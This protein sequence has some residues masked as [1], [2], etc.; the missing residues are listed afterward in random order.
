MQERTGGVKVLIRSDGRWSQMDATRYLDESELQALLA[1]AAD[2]IPGSS[3]D[4]EEIVVYCR[5]FK[6]AAGPI[7]LVG[8][9]AAGSITVMEAKLYRNQDIKRKVVG[10][11][12]DYAARLWQTSIE[13]LVI[14]FTR[15]RG[16][17]PFELLRASAPADA[18]WD[19]SACRQ[20]VAARLA[21]G[22]FR[23][24]IAVDEMLPLER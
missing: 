14:G 19:E 15:A 17:D 4:G 22:E 20:Q 24:L 21:S 12:L 9:G 6:T 11:V 3:L 1:D 16:R 2:V 5:E 23:L 8:V 10:Q 18:E 7:D 13:E